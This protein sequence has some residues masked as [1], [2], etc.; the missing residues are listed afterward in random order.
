MGSEAINIIVNILD[1]CHSG[2]E[3]PPPAARR[4]FKQAAIKTPSMK[5]KSNYE[6]KKTTTTGSG[7][8]LSESLI[9]G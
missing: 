5:M 8:P 7:H 3:K 1:I 9:Y 2:D 4:T 6:K